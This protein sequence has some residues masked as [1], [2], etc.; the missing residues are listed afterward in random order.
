MRITAMRLR[1]Y[2]NY[3][4]LDLLPAPG[5]NVLVGDNAAGKT[6]VLE[7]AFLAALG[8]SHRTRTD[9]ELIKTGADCGSLDVTVATRA[10]TRS[11]GVRLSRKDRRRLLIDGAS[12]ARS[13]ELMGV[14]NV[15][16]FAP[17]DLSLVKDGPAERRRFL[18][19]ALCQERPACY[20]LLQRYGAALRQRNA[21]LRREEA[22]SPDEFLPWEEQLAVTGAGIILARAAF[23]LRLNEAAKRIHAVISDGSEDLSAAYAPNV[24][25]DDEAALI[26]TIRKR[27]AL[28]RTRD[29]FRGGTGTGPHRDD[30]ALLINGADARTFGSQGQQRT[31]VLSLKL[32]E[33]EILEKS[34]GE[35]PVL[36]LDDVF[37]ELDRARQRLLLSACENA[38]T[39]ITCTHID[40]L[41]NAGAVEMKRFDVAQGRITEA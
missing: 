12:P 7:A 4:S 41:E 30:M 9:A 24:P 26:E 25:P 34:A 33:L 1:A 19:M 14:L 22:A 16:L 6:N 35:P 36:L 11:I 23:L 29:V 17:E 39:F 40:A 38:Q 37:S 27:L 18:S 2:R 10:G 15:V 3:E 28:E 20:Y 5:L 21:L 31:A 13:G 8:R 32:A